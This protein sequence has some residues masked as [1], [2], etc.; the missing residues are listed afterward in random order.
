MQTLINSQLPASL[1]VDYANQGS[2]FN[3]TFRRRV[4]GNQL[5]VE[6]ALKGVYR[7]ARNRTP[8]VI[9]RVPWIIVEGMDGSGKST[10]VRQVLQELN[11]HLEPGGTTC[12]CPMPG[13]TDLGTEL[14]QLLLD[15][16]L[17][18]HPSLS[19][20][21]M[22]ANARDVLN[23][24]MVPLW[25]S[26]TPH[27]VIADRWP[28]LSGYVYQGD[29]FKHGIVNATGSDSELLAEAYGALLAPLVFFI[30]V[31]TETSL[32]RRQP[33]PDNPFEATIRARTEQRER[34]EELADL[35]PPRHI[36]VVDNDV[37]DPAALRKIVDYISGECLKYMR[38]LCAHYLTT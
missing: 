2:L 8:F 33:N 3:T 29:H 25:D 20:K 30:R 36:D 35:L 10:I 22:D 9:P 24:I 31:S 12:I 28:T 5:E 7:N 11:E 23:R 1:L 4:F 18:I 17:A 13:T 38:H 27:V 26:D 34:Y 37:D 14:R 19:V 16:E 32:R 21:L 6:P 15:K